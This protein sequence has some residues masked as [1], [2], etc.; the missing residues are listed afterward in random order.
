VPLGRG[1]WSS[2][3]QWY[4]EPTFRSHVREPDVSDLVYIAQ[5]MD[6]DHVRILGRNWAGHQA[7]SV[8][9][10]RLTPLVDLPLRLFPSMSSD[11]YMLGRKPDGVALSQQPG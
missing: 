11:I 3:E 9:V 1:K 8:L 2:M 5:D 7:H 6:L 10:R 4:E